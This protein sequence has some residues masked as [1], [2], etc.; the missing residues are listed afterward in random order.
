M[1]LMFL[2][3]TF[4]LILYI[5]LI[6]TVL[7]PLEPLKDA[8]EFDSKEVLVGKAFYQAF[9]SAALFEEVQKIISIQLVA[10]YAFIKDPRA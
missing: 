3:N 4:F 6:L 5:I 7:E 2:S 10:K 1:T 9:I 8:G